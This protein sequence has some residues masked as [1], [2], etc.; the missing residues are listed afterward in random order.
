M[1]DWK[2]LSSQVSIPFL[3]HPSSFMKTDQVILTDTSTVESY[4]GVII[5]CMPACASV[6]RESSSKFSPFR[7]LKSRLSRT[8]SEKASSVRRN[9]IH[10]VAASD[11]S[12]AKPDNNA[13]QRLGGPLSLTT[14]QTSSSD[15]E[16]I[17]QV[18]NEETVRG[19]EI[20]KSDVNLEVRSRGSTW[21]ECIV[22]FE[23][24]DW[25][26]FQRKKIFL[27]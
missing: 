12:K 4:V 15:E 16:L 26:Y 19:K 25:K 13:Y 21:F 17:L 27:L 14:F 8:K 3:P 18:E 11:N 2:S 23:T 6:F 7:L 20:S 10:L 1:E 9:N 5:V 24:C 22:I